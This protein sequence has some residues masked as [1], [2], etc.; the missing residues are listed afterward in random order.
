MQDDLRS[1]QPVKALR[2]AEDRIKQLEEEITYLQKELFEER[3]KKTKE[4]IEYH[5]ILD[6]SERVLAGFFKRKEATV[7]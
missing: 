7:C 1:M 4:I 2:E 5:Y 3:K 6:E